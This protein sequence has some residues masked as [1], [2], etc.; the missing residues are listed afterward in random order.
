[1][2]AVGGRAAVARELDKLCAP[3]GPLSV[4]APET[5]RR[6]YGDGVSRLRFHREII[7]GI[8]DGQGPVD[9]G[10]R[11]VIVT[12]GPPGAGKSRSVDAFRTQQGGRWRTIDPDVVKTSI[13]RRALIDGIYGDLLARQLADGRP[14]MPLELGGLVHAESVH[15]ADLLLEQCMGRGEN[16]IIEGTLRWEG[17]PAEHAG[18]LQRYGYER[19][20]V[21][22]IE[23]PVETALEQARSRWWTDRIDPE[24]T[25]GGRFVPSALIRDCYLDSSPRSICH[26][27]GL[28]L[29]RR[30]RQIDVKTSVVMADELASNVIILQTGEQGT[31]G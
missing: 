18:R 14:I 12:A 13:I 16:I 26:N 21:L 8:V 3:D 5:T 2:T 31:D 15:V 4:H 9:V 28:E 11:A 6:I 22:S 23:V 30:L 19:A 29:A 17:M 25:L 24:A 27:N 10:G 1:M 20:D 7:Q